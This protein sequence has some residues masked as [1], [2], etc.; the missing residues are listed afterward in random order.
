MKKL[1]LGVCWVAWLGAGCAAT[2]VR[3]GLPPG[4]AAPGYDERWHPAFVLGLIP[5]NDPYDLGRICPNGWSQVTV[6]RDPFTL[7][8]GLAT[9]FIYAP[10]RVTVVCAEHGVSGPPPIGGYAPTA[11]SSP[12]PHMPAPPGEK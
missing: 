10:S 1:R 11:A 4:N 3:S 5:G 9:L 6:N 12:A 7:L 8:A 2:T